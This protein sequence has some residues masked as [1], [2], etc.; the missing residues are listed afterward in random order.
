MIIDS[1]IHIGRWGG[2]DSVENIIESALRNDIDLLLTSCLGEYG[3]VVYPS[4]EQVQK[5][6]DC[7]L[8]AIGNFP[9]N[10]GGLCYV[11]PQFAQESIDEIDR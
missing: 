10:I 6:N 9:D 11:N 2:G 5:A 8:E 3:Y 1:H 7:L 4:V